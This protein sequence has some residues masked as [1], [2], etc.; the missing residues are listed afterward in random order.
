MV[1][2]VASSSETVASGTFICIIAGPSN[3]FKRALM[4]SLKWRIPS[5]AFTESFEQCSTFTNQFI[6]LKAR[7]FA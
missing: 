6:S 4:W 1:E 7:H 2:S 5:R 3:D